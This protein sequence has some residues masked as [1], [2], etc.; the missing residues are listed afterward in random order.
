MEIM[1]ELVRVLEATVSPDQTAL[2]SAQ[3]SLE[4]AAQ[5]DF[6]RFLLGLSEVLADAAKSQV[7][8]MAAGLQLKNALTSKDPVVKMQYQQR[9]L[10]MDPHLRTS[11]KRF[12]LQTLGTEIPRPSS[13]AQCV[14]CI[15]CAEIP[16]NQWPDLI[17]VM[18]H[19]V[20]NATS[21]ESLK[22]S[23]LEAIGYMCQD[24]EPDHLASQSNEILTAIVQGM[25]KEEPS[26]HVRLA[27]T[28][29]LLNSLE[30]T[31][32]NFDKDAERHFIMQVV[33]EGTQCTDFR[34]KVAALQC[35]VKIMSLYYH[36][37]ETY[38]GP[39]LFAITVE[40]MKN[41]EDEV[42]LQGIE[43]WSTVCDEEMDLAIEQS[44]AQEQGRPPEHI[45]RFYAKGALQYLVPLL[46]QTLTK[47]EETDDDDEW[48]PCKAAGVCLMLLAT[49]CE[50]DVVPHILPFVKDNIKH[51]DWH[52]REASVM[53]FGSI[54]EGPEPN[55]L[56]PLV[57]QA[58]PILVELLTDESVVVRDTTAWT[59][60]RICELLPDAAINDTYLQPLLEALKTGL[61]AEPRVAANVCWAISSLAEA[62]YEA[63]EIPEDAEEPT[64]Y[65]I[66]SS[67]EELVSKLLATTDRADAHQSNLRSAAYEALMELVKNSAKDC[68]ATV[69]QTI[70]VVL[71]RIQSVLQ[72]ESQSQTSSER[73]Q[74]SDLQSL[75]CATLQSV[76]R[77][78]EVSDALQI[79]DT[80]MTVLLQMFNSSSGR[81]GGVQED[82]LMAVGTLIEVIGCEFLKYMEAFKPFLLLALKNYAEYQ[83]CLA[84]VGLI[85]DL[86]RALGGNLLP[87]CDELM[88]SLLENLGNEVVH[89]SVKPQILSVFG[90]IALAIGPEF[91]KYLDVVMTT[92]LQATQANVEKS[93]YDMIDYLNE[94]REGCLEA[95]TGIVQGLKGDAD[96]PVN[97]DVQLVQP[98][99]THMINFVENI[100]QDEDHSDSNT[101]AAAGLIGD[102]CTA[103]C[104]SMLPLVE[105]PSIQELLQEGRRSKTNKTKT[106]ASWATKEI[107]KLKSAQ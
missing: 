63:A 47:Q 105:K 55:I 72:L 97:A 24:M 95:Y 29:A 59:I 21:T 44:E 33:C 71:E 100:A 87:F 69:Q 65:Y 74:Y 61:A 67:F 32:A 58:M 34:V 68:Y 90:D 15:A 66:S 22:E 50:D 53:A 46:T 60:G 86:S 23:T 75:L 40:A 45:S 39:A 92:L 81:S 30:F 10:S 14:A 20:T 99:V 62:A 84:A 101:S 3:E 11:I 98:H 107:R 7:A 57:V 42:A 88:Y 48:N 103:F 37:M 17:G 83:V 8:R 19:N 49:C 25:R 73:M 5:N 27:A 85:G 36:H 1:E 76:L 16:H 96:K 56:K 104:A 31:K 91:K 94:L 89:R 64:T 43:F 12:V 106:L 78:M 35:L 6:N 9:W 102:L 38:M 70:I 52:Y 77:K 54:L 79:S 2:Q 41:E 80:V 4:K 26:N 93:D 51:K 82:A 13:A 18:V 28:N